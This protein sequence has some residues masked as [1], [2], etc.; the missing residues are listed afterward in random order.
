MGGG[1]VEF[2]HIAQG[3][4]LAVAE[5]VAYGRRV[6]GRFALLRRQGAQIVGGAMDGLLTV[7][8]LAH[9]VL[10]RSFAFGCVTGG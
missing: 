4:A 6:Q 10:L 5:V 2:Q 8:H 1:K 7:R 3:V 9:L